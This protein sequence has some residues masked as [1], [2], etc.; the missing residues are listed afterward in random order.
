MVLTDEEE[1]IKQ[2]AI[3]YT[4]ANKKK[5]AR[6]IACTETYVGESNPVSVFMAGS[7]GAG[8]TE[9]SKALIDEFGGNF[10]FGVYADSV[11]AP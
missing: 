3:N 11:L 1:R 5:I 7:P 8:K 2:K 6:R 4:R 9:A 10:F